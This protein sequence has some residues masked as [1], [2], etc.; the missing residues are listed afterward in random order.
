L[1]KAI[2]E[3]AIG[4]A[5]IGASV[6]IPGSGIAL[7]GLAMSQTAA[8]SSL[9]SMGA[10][11]ALSG[12][13][14]GLAALEGGHSGISVGVSSPV[15]PWGYIYGTQKVGGVKIF[16]ESNNNTGGDG[17][18]SHNK[19]L[20][21]VYA[22]ACHPSS[23]GNFQFR[24]DG[25]QVLVNPSGSGYASYSP[26]QLHPSITSMSRDANGLV[27]FQIAEGIANLD[28]ESIQITK[29][30][31]NT[32][33]GVWI[34]TQPNPADDTTFTFVCG[35]PVASTTGGQCWTLYADYKDKIYIEFLNGNHTSTFQRLLAAGTSW[36]ATDLCLGRTLVY[37]Q[38]GYD[39]GVFPSS[40]P[41]VS[42]IIDGK[43]D[44]LDPRTGTRGFTNNA[45]LC[46]ADYMSLPP[47]QGG[48][49]LAIG[50][51]IPTPQLIAAAN[52]C[53]ETVP[54]AGGGTVARYACN[55]YVALNQ[56]RGMILKNMLTSCAGR[57]S[58]Q[59]GQYSI[60]PGAWV[61]P[62][63]SLCDTDLVGTLQWKPRLSIRNTANAVKGTY[64][65]PENNWQLGDVPPYMCDYEHGFG[66]ITDPG[67]GDAYLLEDN[68][69]RIFKEAHF[70]C[71]TDSATAQRLEKI[72]LM[73][74]R[75]QGRGT[76]RTT[77]KG[78][79][80]VA[81][82]VIQFTHPRYGWANKYFEVL[83]SRL[84]ID[85][86]AGVPALAVELDVAET[87]PSIY[88]WSTAEQLTPQ[89]Y[90]EP[91]NVGVMAVNPPEA[92][93]TYS[94]PGETV[95]GVTYPNTVSTGAD[96]LARNSLYVSWTSPNDTFVTDGG[97][98]EVQWQPVGATSWT[99]LSLLGCSASCCYIN[100]VS[101]GQS[102]NV[103]LRSIN[104]AGV[105]S[106]WV[107]VGPATVSDTYSTLSVEAVNVT[108]VLTAAHMPAGVSSLAL[109]SAGAATAALGAADQVGAG[110]TIA[111]SGTGASGL[112]TLT[113]GTG[114]LAAG[115][116]CTV[117]F[118]ATLAAAPNGVC[119]ANGSSIPG[120][121]WT[122]STTQLT[123]S[124][125]TVL[126]TGTTYEIGYSL[127]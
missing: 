26:T 117:D 62:S 50:T 51:D 29:A 27:T 92:V 114:E 13:M 115:T 71:T 64:T 24:I 58:Y 116:I 69:E 45:A 86:S 59:G 42:F 9:V 56:G 14:S 124:V 83:S 31:D 102:Y 123:I 39:S 76:L 120:L 18:T 91:T 22:L 111:V 43:N 53:D 15:G 10:S 97:H 20:H 48:F 80:A 49:G 6:L 33:N 126:A 19:Q 125:S 11:M 81:L 89:G 106:A 35:G 37:I 25:K 5:A 8:V 57:L 107:Q 94:G 100:N 127:S 70:P 4:A 119:A 109:A 23:I 61:A 65:S 82:D 84:V 2:T 118:P 66:L 108:G 55:T 36:G 72:E 30:Q 32:F 110:A 85:K 12:A 74:T 88:N 44:I 3:V 68:G 67:Q 112:I 52:I 16:E 41:N 95:S 122:T 96:G 101:D 47:K 105:P 87:D 98:I 73:R 63:L 28:G 7:M 21:R 17:S 78:Y 54:L 34:V 99:P 104:C 77:M 90:A 113:T 79:Q 93:T 60:F 46:V 103:Q 75:Y 121:S 40:I 1:A 38:M